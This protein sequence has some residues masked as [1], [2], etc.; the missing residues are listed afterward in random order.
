MEEE[1]RVLED[2]L[3]CGNLYLDVDVDDEEEYRL[4]VLGKEVYENGE[5]VW[6]G[7]RA[8][9]TMMYALRLSSYHSGQG[10][11]TYDVLNDVGGVFQ[12]TNEQCVSVAVQLVE[13]VFMGVGGEE[14]QCMMDAKYWPFDTGCYEEDDTDKPTPCSSTDSGSGS[15]SDSDS[16]SVSDSD[17]GLD[18][19]SNPDVPLSRRALRA[20]RKSQRREQRAM[21]LQIDI[22]YAIDAEID[23]CRRTCTSPCKY[24]YEEYEPVAESLKGDVLRIAR[25]KRRWLRWLSQDRIL[26][27]KKRTLKKKRL[28]MRNIMGARRGVTD[29]VRGV[30][31]RVRQAAHAWALETQ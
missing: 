14:L 13:P 16:G 3:E 10:F 23:R 24:C 29:G 8:F 5:L 22:G 6:D 31:V 20:L 26:P 7:G 21:L 18:S 27:E 11:P 9:D 28:Q 19:D 30:R 15:G 2:A 25:R 12:Y 4:E 17:S 1:P